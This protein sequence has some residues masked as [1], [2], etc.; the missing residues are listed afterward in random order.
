M[1]LD[2]LSDLCVLH[3]HY[4]KVDEEKTNRILATMADEKR[5]QIDF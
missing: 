3:C 4:E 5:R 2:R 1:T